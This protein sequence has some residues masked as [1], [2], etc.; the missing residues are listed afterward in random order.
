MAYDG[1]IT[2]AIVKELN[3]SIIDGRVEKIYIP[4]KSEVILNIHAN[5]SSLKLLISIDANNARIHLT[6]HNKENTY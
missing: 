4:N 6:N 5:K 2:R 1:L 3:S